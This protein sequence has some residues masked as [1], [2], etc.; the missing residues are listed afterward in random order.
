LAALFVNE[1]IEVV[2]G[3]AGC[4]FTE[5]LM[6]SIFTASASSHKILLRENLLPLLSVN[7]TQS[8]KMKR[9]SLTLLQPL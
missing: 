3:E 2:E 8:L 6:S 7:S 5:E 1:G 9:Y 4:A